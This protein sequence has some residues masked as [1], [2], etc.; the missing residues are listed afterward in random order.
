[1]VIIAAGA[2]DRLE[3]TDADLAAGWQ[4]IHTQHLYVL[5]GEHVLAV[6]EIHVDADLGDLADRGERRVDCGRI[7]AGFLQGI[8]DGNDVCIAQVLP[9]QGA[10]IEWFGE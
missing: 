4:P 2:D 8:L 1:M 9:G 6:H 7:F 5:D 10:H 3:L